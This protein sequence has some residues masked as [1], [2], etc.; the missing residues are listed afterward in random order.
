M[1]VTRFDAD[2]KT[3]FIELTRRNLEI[4]LAKL[5]D[6]NSARTI[7]KTDTIGTIVVHAVEDKEHYSDRPPGPMIIE[8]QIW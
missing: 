6:P 4:L 5:A 7:I 1:K 3:M 2:S 8:G